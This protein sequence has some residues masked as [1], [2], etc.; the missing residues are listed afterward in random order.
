MFRVPVPCPWRTCRACEAVG[1]KC[2]SGAGVFRIRVLLL[3]LPLR[4]VVPAPRSSAGVPPLSLSVFLV[5][6][7]S[8]FFFK[9]KRKKKKKKIFPVGPI[10]YFLSKIWSHVFLCR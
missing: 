5:Y 7:F 4:F 3:L 8:V 6:S 9:K 1:V 2:A 10:S